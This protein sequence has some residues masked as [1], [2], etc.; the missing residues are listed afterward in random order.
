LEPYIP[1]KEPYIPSKEPYISSKE[2]YISSKAF[3]GIQGFFDRILE[4][5]DGI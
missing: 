4:S 3:H 5:V 2:P 1:S